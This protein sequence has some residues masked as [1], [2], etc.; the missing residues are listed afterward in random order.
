MSGM[1]Q[2][3]VAAFLPLVRALMLEAETTGASGAEKH[4]AVSEGAE[5]LY[6]GLQEHG[7]IKE[8][9]AVS[10]DAVAP[11]LV[12]AATGLIS[13]L[14]QVF[15]RIFGKTWRFIQAKV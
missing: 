12:P 5:A 3:A 11:F 2:A 8:I 4:A 15:N 6:R 1:V 13:I 9:R 7:G 14:A 10:W